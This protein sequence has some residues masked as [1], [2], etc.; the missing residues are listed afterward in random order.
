M[1]HWTAQHRAFVIKAYFK[2]CDSVI[3]T[4]HLFRIHFHIPRHDSVPSHNTIKLWVNDFRQSASA[5]KR[6]PPGAVQTV[7]TPENV[8]RVRAAVLHSPTHS[9]RRQRTALQLSAKLA[10]NVASDLNFDPYKIAVDQELSDL[11]LITRQ[12]FAERFLQ[13]MAEEDVKNV[14]LMT[15]EAHFGLSGCVNKHSFRYWAPENPKRL[16]ER[17][18]HSQR[19]TV[20]CGVG[21]F[22]IIGPY[23]FGDGAVVTVNSARYVEMLHNFV[24]PDLRNRG[25]DL[26][27]IWFQQD[28]MTAHTARETI[29]VALIVSR[30][31][32]F[33]KW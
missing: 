9:A 18:L 29:S 2:N 8:A 33:K 15:D 17:P 14:L 12:M 23:F 1:E 30:T 7:R 27:T 11:D 5:V 26:N 10:Q 25:I 13:I 24:E 28:R 16:H 4:Q 19:V 32:G 22:G 3:K 31:C 20:W 6:K 21:S